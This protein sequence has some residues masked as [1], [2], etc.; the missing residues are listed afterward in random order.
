MHF[1]ILFLAGTL[2]AQVNTEDS[3]VGIVNDS[4]GAVIAKAGVTVTNTDTGLTWTAPP[5]VLEP[6]S[7]CHCRP[8]PIQFRYS[9]LASV[10]SF[11]R[12]PS[13]DRRSEAGA[14]T[15]CLRLECLHPFF[16]VLLETA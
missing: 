5:T 9:H 8:A 1:C 4:S 14:G 12:P 16:I 2:S 11:F 13:R 15:T 6:F 7:F 3:I 10:L